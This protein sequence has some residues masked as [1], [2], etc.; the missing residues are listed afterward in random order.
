MTAVR[1][2]SRL[3]RHMWRL[4]RGGQ[5]RFRLETFGLY[6]PALP[7]EAPWWR[8]SP[9]VLGLLAQRVWLYATWVEHM[10]LIQERDAAKWRRELRSRRWFR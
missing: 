3:G 6:F 4:W 9:R 1:R 8:V 7:Y 10:E 5:L 2:L